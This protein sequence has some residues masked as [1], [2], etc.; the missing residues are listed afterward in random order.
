MQ[1]RNRCPICSEVIPKRFTSKIDT[2]L[3]NIVDSIVKILKYI[4]KDDNVSNTLEEPNK[5]A[6]APQM[7][8]N[9]GDIVEIA[10]R[11]WPGLC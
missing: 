5:V 9:V 3:V 7:D 4:D 11:L 10:P 2:N 8:I 6:V 1:E